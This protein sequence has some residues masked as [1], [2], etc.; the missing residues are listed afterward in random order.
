MPCLH[1]LWLLYSLAVC[2]AQST[3][4]SQAFLG[5]AGIATKLDRTKACLNRSS[6]K[7]PPKSA[8]KNKKQPQKTTGNKI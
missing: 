1:I 7:S 4:M 8:D 3:A 5:T 2:R 6:R